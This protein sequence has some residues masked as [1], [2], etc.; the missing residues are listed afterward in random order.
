MFRPHDG[1]SYG[2]TNQYTCAPDRYPFS[3][4]YFAAANPDPHIYSVAANLNPDPNAHPGPIEHT[5]SHRNPHRNYGAYF[6]SS[7]NPSSCRR[8]G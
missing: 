7:R 5:Y 4:G 2:S 6:G 8:E 1:R 3:H